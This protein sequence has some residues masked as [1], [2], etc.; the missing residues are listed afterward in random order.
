MTQAIET[1]DTA[2]AADACGQCDAPG[3]ATV[4]L[5][6]RIDAEGVSEART[7]YQLENGWDWEMD[8]DDGESYVQHVYDVPLALPPTE[9]V[10]ARLVTDSEAA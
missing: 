5:F 6:I 8:W 2:D 7:G 10:T 3:L 1:T 4:R 9:S